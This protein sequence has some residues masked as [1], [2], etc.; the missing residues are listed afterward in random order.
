MNNLTEIKRRLRELTGDVS[1]LPVSCEVVSVEGISC[2]VEVAGG[3]QIPDVRL[4]ATLANGTDEMLIIPKKG[5]KALVW[6]VTGDL[7]DLVLVKIDQI[8]SIA[9]KQDGLEI[10]IDSVAKK[11]TVKN[12]SISLKS[13]MQEVHDLIQNLKVTTPSGPS[14]GVLPDTTTALVQFKTNFQQLLND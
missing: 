13:L 5:S 4:R 11:V 14:T 1:T 8:E 2:T 6:S 12:D 10:F 7:T 9:Y 3:L